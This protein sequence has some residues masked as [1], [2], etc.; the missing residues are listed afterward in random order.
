MNAAGQASNTAGLDY[1]LMGGARGTRTLT[2]Q[3]IEDGAKKIRG[4]GGES[5]RGRESTQTTHRLQIA[6]V[7]QSLARQWTVRQDRHRQVEHYGMLSRVVGRDVQASHGH[8]S[9]LKG[10]S[11]GRKEGRPE[12]QRLPRMLTRLPWRK[13][14]RTF[15]DLRCVSG[16]A[17]QVRMPVETYVWCTHACTL[18]NQ[19]DKMVWASTCVASVINLARYAEERSADTA[20]VQHQ[21]QGAATYTHERCV[22]PLADHMYTNQINAVHSK[23]QSQ[24][25]ACCLTIPPRVAF[26]TCT[27]HLKKIQKSEGE[28]PATQ[29]P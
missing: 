24:S 13:I 4:N 17:L 5:G 29:H 22:H 15:A 26:P 14:I 7:P 8:G 21:R 18:S 19:R 11:V 20:R 10:S 2:W 6:L 25:L 16:V 12:T 27:E 3:Q 1:L 23:S 28:R 9:R